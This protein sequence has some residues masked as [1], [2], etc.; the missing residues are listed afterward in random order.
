MAG[1]GELIGGRSPKTAKRFIAE[2]GVATFN[3]RGRRFVKTSD[4]EAAIEARRIVASPKSQ[5]SS[6]KEMLDA[7]S[8]KVVKRRAS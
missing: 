7:I 1:V 8:D 5:P 6:L 3:I 2:A 4:V